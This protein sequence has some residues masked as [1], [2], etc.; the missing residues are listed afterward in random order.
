MTLVTCIRRSFIKF[1]RT[2]KTNTSIRPRVLYEYTTEF[3]SRKIGI[4]W[5]TCAYITPVCGV[6]Y[7]VSIKCLA[8]TFQILSRNSI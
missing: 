2:Q 7:V 5:V 1:A 4:T 3:A 8:I 6:T